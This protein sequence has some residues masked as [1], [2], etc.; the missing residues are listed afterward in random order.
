[1]TKKLHKKARNKDGE[2]P[3]NHTKSKSTIMRIINESFFLLICSCD[4]HLHITINSIMD[5]KEIINKKYNQ[6]HKSSLHAQY[7]CA[8][9][10]LQEYKGE[11]AMAKAD[12]NAMS[13][14]RL[15]DVPSSLLP[16]YRCSDLR[17]RFPLLRIYLSQVLY[18]L[19]Q[20]RSDTDQKVYA[21]G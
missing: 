4:T 15:F 5:T 11:D 8:I 17:D 14:E 19:L 16:A 7:N 10:P 6:K 9:L 3:A 21:H 2:K 20:Y 18:L 13:N 12:A 1:M